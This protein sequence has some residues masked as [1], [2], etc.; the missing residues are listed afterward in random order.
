MRRRPVWL[1][2][3]LIGLACALGIGSRRFGDRLP[4]FVAAYAGDALWALAAFLGIG[5]AWRRA[6]TWAVAMAALGVSFGVEVSQLYR[7]PW[8]DAVRG[9]TVGAL[10]LGHGF[11]WSDLVC[12]VVGV[13]AGVG[14]EVM[15]AGLR[16]GRG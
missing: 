2:F 1:W 12:Y 10:L 4:A 3:G 5:L 11:L 14:I 8:I 16:P 9:T 13:M 15:M 6:S 7:A